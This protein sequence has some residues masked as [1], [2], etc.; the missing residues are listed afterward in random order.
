MNAYASGTPS[1][2]VN[3]YMGGRIIMCRLSMEADF[4][5]PL[6]RLSSSIR[7]TIGEE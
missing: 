1:Q 5:G 6:A 4:P 2:P 7:C 3:E